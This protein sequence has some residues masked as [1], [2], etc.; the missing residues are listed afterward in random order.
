MFASD[1]TLASA[2][3]S[4]PFEY[5]TVDAATTLFTF[6][7]NPGRTCAFTLVSARSI[8]GSPPEE[9]SAETVTTS[10]DCAAAVVSCHL[11][12]NAPASGAAHGVKNLCAPY[13]V[14]RFWCTDPMPATSYLS[15][16]TGDPA[17]PLAAASSSKTWTCFFDPRDGGAGARRA[18]RPGVDDSVSS[19][20]FKSASCLF[21]R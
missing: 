6:G 8:A 5:V 12:K 16:T 20:W 15:V 17:Y 4:A 18:F 10:T 2:K 9:I 13:G 14:V 21:P 11:A 1:S 3:H 19:S 7:S